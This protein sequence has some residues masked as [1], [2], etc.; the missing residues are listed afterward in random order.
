MLKLLRKT[1]TLDNYWKEYWRMPSQDEALKV[2]EKYA[3]DNHL[4]MKA[5]SSRFIILDERYYEVIPSV[6]FRG[7]YGVYIR[8]CRK[9]DV[10]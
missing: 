9:E 5:L 6:F 4:S 3:E 7:T 2:A 1:L 10:L 8:R